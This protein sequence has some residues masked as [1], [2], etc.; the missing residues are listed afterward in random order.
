MVQQ[1]T[2]HVGDFLVMYFIQQPPRVRKFVIHGIYET[3]LEEFD[4]LYVF[5]D[6]A[7]IQKLNDWNANQVGGFEITISDFNRLDEIG[8]EVYASIGSDLNARTIREIYPQLFDWLKLQDVNGIII[9]ILMLI[10]AGINMISALIIII[11][12]RI[13]M[14]GTLK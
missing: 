14:I 9:I 11:L 6:L 8:N 10:V 1:G 7:H 12:E 3:G 4:D 13:N 2:L 5:C